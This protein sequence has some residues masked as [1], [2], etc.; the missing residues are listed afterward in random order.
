MSCG[1][2]CL[3][4]KSIARTSLGA[5]LTLIE[6]Y[7]AIEQIRFSD[8]LRVELGRRA[9]AREALVPSMVMPAD[10]ENAIKQ[11]VTRSCLVAGSIHRLGCASRATACVCR[12]SDD[13][14]ASP[15]GPPSGVGHWTNTREACGA[16]YGEAATTQMIWTPPGGGAG[17]RDRWFALRV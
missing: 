5:E 8:R 2:A 15:L 11:G 12:V 7:L 4:P 14:R 13:G 16:L 9:A 1:E 17:G 10:R 6:Q 3:R